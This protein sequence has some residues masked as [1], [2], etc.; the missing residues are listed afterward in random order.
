MIFFYVWGK[1]MQG[2]YDTVGDL[3]EE[4]AALRS[5]I[6]GLEASE[7]D[8]KRGKEELRK[9]VDAYRKNGNSNSCIPSFLWFPRT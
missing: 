6:A 9:T 1:K 4:I 8:Q 3:K 5:R 2:E 7:E